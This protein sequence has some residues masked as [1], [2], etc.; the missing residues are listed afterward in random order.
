MKNKYILALALGLSASLSAQAFDEIYVTGSTAMRGNFYTAIETPGLVFTKAP[1]FTGWGGEDDGVI[2][3]AA[4]SKDDYM[5]FYGTNV[6]SGNVIVVNCYWGGSEN[7]IL[8]VASNNVAGF[9]DSFIDDSLITTGA[10]GTAPSDNAGNPTTLQ[11][12]AAQICMADNAQTFSRTKKPTLTTIASGKGVGAITFRW[13]RNNGL[14]T[15]ANTNITDSQI[16]QALSGGAP[17][18]VFTGVAGQSDFVYVSGRD[19]F[20]GTRV[21][22]FG[23]TGFGITSSPQQIELDGAGNMTDPD[24]SDFIGDMGFT[25]GGNLA[26]SLAGS[27]A[28]STDQVNGGT[29]FSV[30]AYLSYGDSATAIGLGATELAYD[31]VPFSVQAVKEGTY[32]FWGNEYIYENLSTGATTDSKNVFNELG[33]NGLTTGIATTVDGTKVINLGNMDCSRSGPTSPPTHN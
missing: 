2:N 25:S 22:A 27:T 29:G 1:V 30:I 24:G 10:T 28:S 20:S 14:W 6:T 9:N 11:S 12:A 7:G 21:N 8:T 15:G 3:P 31:G 13:V 4:S 16:L 19:K 17:R 23:E 26:N 32:N 18:S 5:A 33:G